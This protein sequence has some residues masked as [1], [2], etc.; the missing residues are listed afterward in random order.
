MIKE[1][2]PE[3]RWHSP[4]KNA[5]HTYGSRFC[6]IDRIT[7]FVRLRFVAE[8]QQYR[9]AGYKLQSG[10]GCFIVVLRNAIERVYVCTVFKIKYVG[11]GFL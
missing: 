9:I 8:K 4:S 6:L 5:D 11:V 3:L 1:E 2:C 10:F 7:C